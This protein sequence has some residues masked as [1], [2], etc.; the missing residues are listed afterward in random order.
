MRK[1]ANQT[2]GV[3]SVQVFE[4]TMDNPEDQDE[5]NRRLCKPDDG[6]PRRP[7]KI[8]R[9]ARNQSTADSPKRKKRSERRHRKRAGIRMALEPKVAPI[10]AGIRAKTQEALRNPA[11]H[12]GARH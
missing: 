10:A 3:G 12:E 1:K 8:G 9:T 11:G 4:L 5:L 2:S 6:D 7:A